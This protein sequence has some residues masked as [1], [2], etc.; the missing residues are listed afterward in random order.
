M[1]QLIPFCNLTSLFLSQP[2]DGGKALSQLMDEIWG[3]VEYLKIPFD[4]LWTMP[5]YLRKY[6]ILRHNEK[7]SAENGNSMTS[8]GKG[9]PRTITGNAVNAYARLEQNK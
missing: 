5:V 7:V 9:S 2:D 4:T 1:A 6:W 3:C 8:Q